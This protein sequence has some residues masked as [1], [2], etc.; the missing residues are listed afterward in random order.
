MIFER[1]T[2][3]R[4]NGLVARRPSVPYG[5]DHQLGTDIR[6]QSEHYQRAEGL[7]HQRRAQPGQGRAARRRRRRA[8]HSS[9]WPR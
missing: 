6:Q 1:R 7:C 4:E 9:T 8:G 3:R 5:P 2:S